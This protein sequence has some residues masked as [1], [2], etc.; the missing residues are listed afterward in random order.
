[1]F[2]VTD[3]NNKIFHVDKNQI[4]NITTDMES[5]DNKSFSTTADYLDEKD[6]TVKIDTV[7]TDS[8]NVVLDLQSLL[9]EIQRDPSKTPKAIDVTFE[10]THSGKNKNFADYVSSS[11]ENDAESWMAPYKKPFLKN[12]DSYSEPLGRVKDYSFGPSEINP[13]RDCIDVTY[14]VTDGD[15]IPKLLDGRYRTMSIG[16]SVGHIKCNIC[17]KDILKDGAFKF[18]GHWRGEKYKDE[19]CT[20]TMTGLGYKEGSV[21][22]MPADDWAQIKKIQVVNEDPE[23]H[24]HDSSKEDPK[25]GTKDSK[26]PE[27]LSVLDNIDNALNPIDP[28]SPS[29]EDKTKTEPLVTDSKKEPEK[30]TEEPLTDPVAILKA[31]DDKIAELELKVTDLATEKTTIQTSLDTSNTKLTD[32]TKQFS[33]KSSEA[34]ILNRALADTKKQC[35]D[36]S[37]YAKSMLVNKIIDFE[38]LSKSIKTTEKDNRVNELTIMSTKDLDGLANKINYDSIKVTVDPIKK[39]KDPAL[40]NT[41]ADPKVGAEDNKDTEEPDETEDKTK[42]VPAENIMDYFGGTSTFVNKFTNAINRKRNN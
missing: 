16:A 28:K 8:K 15:A 10:S 27:P 5:V 26:E 20:W 21:V 23:E 17:G 36:I 31:K 22:N 18:C 13:A 3:E 32:M 29:G 41:D 37:S 7:I 2:E 30:K 6:K 11:M 24:H 35:F 39:A 9:D 12:H 33:D 4:C 14:R 19:M 42:K 40:Q 1:L 38:L 25:K 34:E